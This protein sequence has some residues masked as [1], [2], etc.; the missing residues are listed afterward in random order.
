MH[1]SAFAPFSVFRR[2]W[3]FC[4]LSLLS[5]WVWPSPSHAAPGGTLVISSICEGDRSVSATLNADSAIVDDPTQSQNARQV[6]HFGNDKQSTADSLFSL[7]R[8]LGGSLVLRCPNVESVSC[9]FE[10]TLA[11]NKVECTNCSAC[12]DDLDRMSLATLHRLKD[13]LRRLNL[14]L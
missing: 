1:P 12:S 7:M 6:I 8:G 4:L 9:R 2:A 5:V 3:A 10:A 11:D 14:Y 13:L